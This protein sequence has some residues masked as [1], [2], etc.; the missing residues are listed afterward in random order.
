MRLPNHRIRRASQLFHSL[1]RN[2]NKAVR[3]GQDE[4]PTIP[5]ELLA[6]LPEEDVYLID[7]YLSA[8]ADTLVTTDHGLHESL[9]DSRLVSCRLCD[10]FLSD[11]LA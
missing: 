7:A 11:Y 2:R 10:E 4:T 3:V 9:A 5:S 6:R 1:L 8:N